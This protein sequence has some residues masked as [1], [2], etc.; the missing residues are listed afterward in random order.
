MTTASIV[1][2]DVFRLVYVNRRGSD[3]RAER[4]REHSGDRWIAACA[5]AKNFELVAGD[6][7]YRD[8]PN[9]SVVL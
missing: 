6:G 1:D 8:A 7:I 2:T 4:W 9:L 3:V 5:I